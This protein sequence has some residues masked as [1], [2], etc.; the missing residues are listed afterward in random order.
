MTPKATPEATASPTPVVVPEKTPE[1]SSVPESSPEKEDEGTDT[2][3][4]KEEGGEEDRENENQNN[5]TG[6][7]ETGDSGPGGGNINGAGEDKEALEKKQLKEDSPEETIGNESN[8]KRSYYVKGDQL[9]IQPSTEIE[10]EEALASP[11][12]EPGERIKKDTE[13]VTVSGNNAAQEREYKVGQQTKKNGFF[14]STA[15]K[16]IT[17]TFST[18]LVLA[19]IILFML[20]LLCSVRIFNDDGEGRMIYLGRLLVRKKDEEYSLMITE[21]MTE[22]S[23]TNRYCIKPGF[24]RLGKKEDQELI[25]YR[26]TKKAVAYLSKEMIVIL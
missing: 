19:G 9:L 12:S 17:V 18:L 21:A 1:P 14:Q 20:Y 15:A 6:S 25:V 11:S 8:V 24:F 3:K 26:D 13:K 7:D 2:D 22:K 23:C 4:E 5:K 16:I 10:E